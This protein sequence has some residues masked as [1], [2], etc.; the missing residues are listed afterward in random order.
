MLHGS[1]VSIGLIPVN[2]FRQQS[3]D[4]V[5]LNQ[6]NATSGVECGVLLTCYNVWLMLAVKADAGGMAA[7]FASTQPKQNGLNHCNPP[8][9]GLVTG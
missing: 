6:K 3:V 9:L 8:F 5:H 2:H 7:K 4:C 1:I